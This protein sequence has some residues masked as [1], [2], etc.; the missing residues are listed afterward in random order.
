M[1]E[2]Y[3]TYFNKNEIYDIV[4]LIIGIVLVCRTK[5]RFTLEQF[6][7]YYLYCV[8][9]GMLADHTI[10]K[11]LFDYYDVNDSSKY[12]F[13]DFITYF[14]F[15]T[16]GYL[17]VYIYD[18]FKIKVSHAPAYVLLWSCIATLMELIAVCC[19]VFHYKNGYTIY[20]SFPIYL[21]TLSV[22]LYLYRVFSSDREDSN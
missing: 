10:G 7:L 18:H 19:G 5:K 12:E 15:G 14:M 6:L 13:F 3:D 8:F 11:M 21:L 17:Y 9:I 22:P 16:Y 1:Y 4:T 20:Y 2:V